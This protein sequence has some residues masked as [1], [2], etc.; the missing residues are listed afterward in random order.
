MES[1]L[2]VRCSKVWLLHH[3]PVTAFKSLGS[4]EI[5]YLDQNK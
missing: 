1:G 2:T 4:A 3:A 5:F